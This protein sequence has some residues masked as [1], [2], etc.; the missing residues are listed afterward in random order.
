MCDKLKNIAHGDGLLRI[1]TQSWNIE[2]IGA[3]CGWMVAIDNPI[4]GSDKTRT[5]A[6]SIKQSIELL[7]EIFAE[8]IMLNIGWAFTGCKQ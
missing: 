2:W 7:L 6:M 8:E 5:G 3:F 4:G 1:V